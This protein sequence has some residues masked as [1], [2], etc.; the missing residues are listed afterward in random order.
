[1][2][3]ARDVWAVVPVKEF[4]GAKQRLAAVMGPEQR[5]ILAAT[6]VDDVLS[7][8]AAV[9]GLAGIVVV[10]VDPL[11][12]EMG[13]RFGA[14]VITDGARDGQTAAVTAAAGALARE[15]RSGMLTLPGDIPLVS[16][17]EVSA[18]LAAHRAPRSFSIAPAHDELGSNA[19]LCSPP[20]AVPLRFGDDSFQPHVQA[21]RRHGIEPTIVRLPGIGCDIDH[22]ADLARFMAL[23]AN[24]S[25]RTLAY[26]RSVGVSATAPV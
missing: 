16:V 18:M 20:D 11:A 3:G 17:Q 4:A 19:I 7:V 23:G 9:P 24:S 13:R 22:P 10:T 14:R 25:S 1:L 15:S 8:L 26:L 5:Q 2:N 12:A 6:M 21:A